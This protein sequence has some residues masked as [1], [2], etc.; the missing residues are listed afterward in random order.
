VRSRSQRNT[1]REASRQRSSERKWEESGGG[2]NSLFLVSFPLR[3]ATGQLEQEDPS[4]PCGRL[5]V[6]R[7]KRGSFFAG[8]LITASADAASALATGLCFG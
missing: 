5:L 8:R 3:T 1:A 7:T 6:H 2:D 4:R